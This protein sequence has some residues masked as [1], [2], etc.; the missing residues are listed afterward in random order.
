M[1]PFRSDWTTVKNKGAIFGEFESPLSTHIFKGPNDF[2][3][4]SGVAQ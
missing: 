4:F 3:I 2:V 1:P